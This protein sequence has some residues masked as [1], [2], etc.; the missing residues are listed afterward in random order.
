MEGSSPQS[1]LEEVG[2]REKEREQIRSKC[3]I[4][5]DKTA[6]TIEYWY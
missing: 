6:T 5:R 4:K 3:N 2:W 1:T